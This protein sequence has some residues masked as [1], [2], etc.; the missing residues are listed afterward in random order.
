[1]KSTKPTIHK[2]CI[3]F[4]NGKKYLRIYDPETNQ[5]KII[6][7]LENEYTSSKDNGHKTEPEQP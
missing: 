2:P 3:T 6:T 4:I 7:E 5:F 1:M